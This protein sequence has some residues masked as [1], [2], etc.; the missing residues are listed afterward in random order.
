MDIKK[1]WF[2]NKN[3]MMQKKSIHEIIIEELD[4]EKVEEALR[5]LLNLNTP[6]NYS[7]LNLWINSELN[8]YNPKNIPHYRK[9]KFS[10]S[11]EDSDIMFIESP[12]RKIIKASKVISSTSTNFK[13]KHDDLLL[14]FDGIQSIANFVK[15]KIYELVFKFKENP[16][17]IHI[18]V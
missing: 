17:E 8:G 15:N 18:D 16:Y 1:I 2:N 14:P 11:D 3:T 4:K 12:I 9:I 6:Y 10:C 13:I 7:Q 5:D